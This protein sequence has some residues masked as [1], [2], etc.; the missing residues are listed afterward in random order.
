MIKTKRFLKR[1]QDK[2]PNELIINNHPNMFLY[3]A[4]INVLHGFSFLDPIIDEY[5]NIKNRL[6]FKFIKT[7]GI[8]KIYRDANFYI[9]SNY[10]LGL[11]KSLFPRIGIKPK[12]LKVI[13]P[14]VTKP[15][16]SFPIKRDKRL[17]V[18]IGRLSRDKNYEYLL[19]IAQKLPD[20]NFLIIGA[21][22]RGDEKYFHTLSAK[23]GKNVSIMTNASNNE[24]INAM[25]RAAIFLHLKRKEHFGISIVESMSYGL[26][27]VVPKCGGPWMDIVEK[28]KFGYGFDT[29][30][31]GVE[32]IRGVDFSRSKEIY[33][34]VD[35]FSYENFRNKLSE[36][37]SIVKQ[38]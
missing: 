11:A 31:E 8:Y 14:P 15:Y 20:Y 36:L 1:L 5:G 26:I 13:Y 2:A 34:S 7:S 17:I 21:L 10:T 27:P 38:N 32:A 9:N 37:I 3:K 12:I 28:G 24:K 33:E 18:S 29:I 19:R 23:K 35:R 4:D 25:M 16:I 22:N 30:E 6:L